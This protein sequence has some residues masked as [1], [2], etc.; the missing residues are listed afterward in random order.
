MT[1]GIGYFFVVIAFIIGLS[2][3]LYTGVEVHKQ[4]EQVAKNNIVEN[5]VQDVILKK[6][7]SN[8]D[9]SGE[10]NI[11]K[12]LNSSGDD[13]VITVT[14][15]PEKISPNAK[16]V[17][18]K[19]FTRCGHSKVNRID[20]PK[21]LINFTEEEL[22][23]KYTGWDIEEFSKDQI[24]LSR[25]IDANCDDH[26]VLKEVE[27]KIAIYNELTDDKMNLVE[28][29]DTDVNLLG[30]DDKI[31]LANGIRVYGQAELSSIIED[32]EL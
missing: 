30:E 29:V 4:D 31:A 1:K 17:I 5:S 32:Y 27:G 13:D 21:E 3:G 8:D 15:S 9:L 25:D 26:Y 23:E 19:N 24:V 22:K 11:I 12:N 6:I 18:M 20:I 14:I 7:Q 28:I 2:V 10:D 16:M